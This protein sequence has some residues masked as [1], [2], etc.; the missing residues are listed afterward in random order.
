MWQASKFKPFGV[1]KDLVDDLN[2]NVTNKNNGGGGDGGASLTQL[3]SPPPNHP[4][5]SLSHP[6]HHPQ[7]P[8]ALTGLEGQGSTPISHRQPDN[9]GRDK[10][11]SP[12]C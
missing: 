2:K 12:G 9:N 10:W 6:H 3:E 1:S 5:H 8:G 7:G 4:S 11:P